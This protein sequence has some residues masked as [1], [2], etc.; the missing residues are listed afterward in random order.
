MVVDP[1]YKEFQELA[2]SYNLVPL[3]EEWLVD[4]ETP[5]SVFQKL[6]AVRKPAFLLESVEGG[7]RIGRYS[8]IGLDPVW[9]LRLKDGRLVLNE[10]GGSTALPGRAPLD[11][12]RGLMARCRPAPC[13]R[14]LRFYGGA[15]GYLAYDFARC[16]ERLP[17]AN[18]DELGL[19]DGF[20]LFPRSVLVFDHL[21]HT[22]TVVYNAPAGDDPA[23]TYAAGCREIAAIREL[24]ARTVE[25]SSPATWVR[26]AAVQGEADDGARYVSMVRRAREY[27]LAGDIL[28]A[29]LSRR[30]AVPLECTPFT[31]YRRL[32]SLN[33]SPYMFYL[34]AGDHV[35]LGASPEMLIRVEDGRVLTRPIA[36]TRPR[37]L[38]AA[39]DAALA[40]ELLA[41]PKERAEH[42]MLVDLGRNDLARVCVPGSVRVNQL[43]DVEYFSHVMHIVSEVEGR[44]APGYNALDALAAAFP[45]G[46]VSGAPKVRAMEIIEELEPARRGVYAGAV[47]YLSLNGNLDTCIAI[48]TVVVKD[49]MVYV[50][51]GAGIVADSEPEREFQEV[52][53]KAAVLVQAIGGGGGGRR[54]FDDR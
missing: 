25:M 39:G 37:G 5:I 41:D 24:L 20:F 16:L 21:R 50:Q 4:T 30:V 15:V 40:A 47:G 53:H 31:V 52:I 54:A 26:P 8:F 28:Q 49:G 1:C 34:D 3:A 38:D 27:V 51:A 48:R 46:T 29:V 18:P 12:L 10:A 42:V 13:P 22:L 23:A 7:E 11:V 35:V 19:P 33:P 32:R 17:D 43:M 2:R 9:T 45:A 6:S 36:G 44:L 14:P